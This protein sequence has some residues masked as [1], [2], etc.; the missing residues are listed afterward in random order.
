MEMA[1]EEKGGKRE[2]EREV[3]KRVASRAFYRLGKWRWVVLGCGF[4]VTYPIPKKNFSLCRPTLGQPT[5]PT[6]ADFSAMSPNF[7]IQNWGY[8]VV[9]TF[10]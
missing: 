8:S 3:R 7:Y 1:E 6:L 10:S 4:T 5:L 2:I 9:S